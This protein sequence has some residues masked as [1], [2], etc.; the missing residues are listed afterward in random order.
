[1]Y[2]SDGDIWDNWRENRQKVYDELIKRDKEKDD[3][4]L[5]LSS[6]LSEMD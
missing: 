5:E 4:I 1:M 2:R 6:T 3:E